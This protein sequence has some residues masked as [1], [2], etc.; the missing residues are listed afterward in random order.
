MLGSWHARIF[1]A[2][3][4]LGLTDAGLPASVTPRL[5]LPNIQSVAVGT[6]SRVVTDEVG[7]SVTIPAQVRRIVSLAPNL[8]E[9]I[10]ALGLEDR[11]A[12]DTDYCDVPA[13][14]KA[15]PHIGSPQNPSIEAIVALHPDLVL[16]TTSINLRQTADALARL[17]VPVY[18]TDPHAVR[19]MV[20]SFGRMADL[21]GASQQ[22]AALVAG[23]DARL[24][25]LHTRLADIPLVHV[26]FVVWLDPLIS[27][28][29][30]TFIADALRWAGAESVVLSTLSSHRLSHFNASRPARNANAAPSKLGTA[31]DAKVAAPFACSACTTRINSRATTT[32]VRTTAS[33]K[34]NISARDFATPKSIP[35]EMVAPDR[36]NPR[37]GKHK[38]LYGSDNPCVS[39]GQVI[40]V[41]QTSSWFP[42]FEDTCHQNQDSHKS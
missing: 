4:T 15:K 30:K 29:Q 38:S 3:M 9:T 20:D 25:T 18:T 13:A 40:C 34:L 19:G 2:L 1:V 6:E 17:G 31:A 28:G 23:L 12:G 10:Y 21:I 36:E 27:I 24:D 16:A 41:G 37:N 42:F 8:T 33:A 35:A 7:R 22:G 26:L 32:G 39:S 14:A 5:S 11:L